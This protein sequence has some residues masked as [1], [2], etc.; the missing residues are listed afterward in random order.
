MT[1]LV[2]GGGV[3]GLSVAYGLLKQGAQVT[4]ID[5]S[6][7]DARASRG[8]FGLVWIQGKGAKAPH[9]AAWSRSSAKLWQG[10]AKDLKEATGIDIAFSQIGGVEYFTDA[11]ALAQDAAGLQGLQDHFDGDYPFEVLEHSRLK[12]LVPEI[13]PKVVGGIHSPM[14]GHVNPLLLLRA[15][16]VAVQQMGGRLQ[17]GAKVTEIAGGDRAYTVTLE[18]GERIEGNALV[19]AAGLGS[20]EYGADLGFDAP[21]RPQQGQ[22]LI[23][24]KLPFFLKYPSGRIRQVN[25]GGVQI[26]ASKAETGADSTDLPTLQ[27]LA[28]Y[29]V[30]VFPLLEHVQL[31]RSWAALR[32]MS[33]DGLPIY[34]RSTKFAGA[35]FVTCHS[36]ITLAAAHAGLLPDWIQDRN[37][38]PDLSLFSESR[39]NV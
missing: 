15:L 5:G 8:N 10:F 3:V 34:Q 9:Y 31:V 22:V 38:A 24:E 2:I 6:D 17:T 4:V 16:S 29:A 25:E 30:D 14:D 21:V 11:D 26:G 28:R 33:P 32:V 35:H 18:T 19:L 36:G 13:G 7:T 20:A 39:F 23:T 37:T 27:D 12:Q 1:T